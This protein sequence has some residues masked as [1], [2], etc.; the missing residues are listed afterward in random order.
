MF[1]IHNLFQKLE[2]NC[3]KENHLNTCNFQKKMLPSMCFDL[4]ET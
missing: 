3:N 2:L 1:T 4:L